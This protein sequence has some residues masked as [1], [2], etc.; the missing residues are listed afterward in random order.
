MKMK[1]AR[2]DCVVSVVALNRPV[3][4]AFF[5]SVRRPGSQKGT[6]RDVIVSTRWASMSIPITSKP[7]EAK[8]AAVQSHIPQAQKG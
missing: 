3:L 6:L 7:L 1:R 2:L 4:K 5:S 8:A